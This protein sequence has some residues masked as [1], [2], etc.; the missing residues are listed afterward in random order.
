M[1]EKELAQQLKKTGNLMD[2]L[3][4]PDWLQKTFVAESE[5]DGNV[6]AGAGLQTYAKQLKQASPEAFK[7]QKQQMQLLSIFLPALHDWLISWEL[8]PSF[9][10]V[11][12]E[13]QRLVYGHLVQASAGQSEW[14][15][16]ALTDNSPNSPTKEQSKQVWAK[17]KLAEMLHQQD[18]QVLAKVAA[19]DMEKRILEQAQ[20]Q[21]AVMPIAV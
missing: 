21:H 8:G 17:E 12:A 7:A 4:D 16:E 2:L 13:A 6:E 18:W 19:K 14:L 20:V 3:N 5:C 1:D 9:E 10:V 11:Y 15:E